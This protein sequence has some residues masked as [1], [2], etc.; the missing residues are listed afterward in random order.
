MGRTRIFF[1]VFKYSL[2]QFSPIFL[3]RENGWKSVY[4]NGIL[5]LKAAKFVWSSSVTLI[6]CADYQPT[7]FHSFILSLFLC[8]LCWW[9]SSLYAWCPCFESYFYTFCTLKAVCI[10]VLPVCRLC[11]LLCDSYVTRMYSYVFVC[12]R[13]VPVCTRMLLVFTRV[14]F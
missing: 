9:S 11:V 7:C 12:H 13:C 4:R 6:G 2:F 8:F 1:S 10:R 3:L 14:V 5:C